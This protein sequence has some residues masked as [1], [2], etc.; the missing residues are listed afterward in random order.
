[1][2]KSHPHLKGLMIACL[3]LVVSTLTL[4]LIPY[5]SVSTAN[6]IAVAAE[7]PSQGENPRA[8]F[9]R[10]VRGGQAGY[11]A[12]PGREAGVYI[13][14][15]GVN[16]QA[17][18]T[19]ILAPYGSYLMGAVLAFIAIFFVIRGSIKPENGFSGRT[20]ER[21]SV[22][23]R[24]IH[25][26]TA[27]LFW[28]LALS[29]L[30]LLYGRYVLIPLLG[31]ENFAVTASACK[32]A[33]NLFGPV[34]LLALILLFVAFVRNNFYEK[35]DINWLKNGGGM[36]GRHASAG[37]FNPGEKLWFWLVCL[38]GL[39][40]SFSGIVLDF[41]VLG[42]DRTSMEL[43]HGIHTI[44]ALLFI[45]IS[46]GHIYLGTIGTQ[47]TLKGMTEGSVDLNWAKLH[48]DKWAAEVEQTA[49]T[50]T[51]VTDTHTGPAHG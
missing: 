24:V 26:F 50:K 32:E 27:I 42:L 21:F 22:F 16:W 9:W 44:A 46:F 23:Q 29:G 7:T 10:A 12:V 18:R 11:T 48:H 34:F 28:L 31:A 35:G 3:L 1:M 8:N 6:T 51:T 20:V 40:V 17:Y 49:S 41:S 39:L 47:G 33:H 5:I 30:I 37:R 36:F 43:A 19:R 45:S 13:H 14:G 15:N 25:W 4:P 2:T 38:L